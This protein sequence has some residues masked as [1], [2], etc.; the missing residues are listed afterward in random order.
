MENMFICLVPTIS[1]IIL[2]CLFTLYPSL[3]IVMTKRK[4]M[5][6]YKENLSQNALLYTTIKQVLKN[7]SKT[8]EI[9][10]I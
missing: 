4:E 8:N 3:D 2:M 7:L 5:T 9:S 10:Q 1:V 6:I